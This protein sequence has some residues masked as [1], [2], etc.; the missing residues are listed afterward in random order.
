MSDSFVD[1]SNFKRILN[2]N[3]TVPLGFGFLS[4]FFFC[5]IVYYLLSVSHWVERSVQ[6]VAY[7]HEAQKMLNDIEA[8]MRGYLIA[9]QA[10]F[11]EPYQRELPLFEEQLNLM[12][13]YSKD[14]PEQ[15]ARV[16]RIAMLHGQWLTFS[17]E[18]IGRRSQGQPVVEAVQSK[19]GLELKEEQ[20]RLLN[21]F[22]ARE[23]QI[24]ADRTDVSEVVTTALIGGFLLFS[25]IF[26]GLLVYSGRR[27]LLTLSRTY[28]ESLERQKAHAADLEKQ[29]WYRTGQSQLSDAIIGEL[30]LPA[31]GQGI[32]TFLSRYLEV[33]VGALYVVQDGKLQRVAEFAY[34]ADQLERNRTLEMGVGLVGQAALERRPIALEQLPADYLKVNSALGATAPRSVLIAPVEDSGM[35]NAV[36]ELG[37]LRPLREQDCELLRRIG[38]SIGSA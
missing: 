12:R 9:G 8:S 2:R 3:V 6:G 30:T 20:R 26:S 5:A 36:I 17:E 33:A 38:S 11:L 1:Q 32:L 37:F 28:S 19:R 16:E 35:L 10:P 15:L 7:A 22:I 23:R 21:D 27:D 4:A 34:E 29:A 25:L 13:D 18:V 24:R 14:N 31:L